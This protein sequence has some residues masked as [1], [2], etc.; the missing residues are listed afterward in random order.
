MPVTPQEKKRL[1]YERDRRNTY[2]ENDKSSRK[3]IP[4]SKRLASR[5]TRRS[6]SVAL[7]GVRGN[8]DALGIVEISDDPKVVQNGPVDRVEQRIAGRRL[9][10]F[11]KWRD[12]PLGDVVAFQLERRADTDPAGTTTADTRIKQVEHRLGHRIR[13]ADTDIAPWN[14]R[15][16]MIDG[17]IR[18]RD[19]DRLR[20]WVK[21]RLATVCRAERAGAFT[22]YDVALQDARFVAGLHRD[23]IAATVADLLPPVDTVIR[24]CLTQIPITEREIRAGRPD[25]A[26]R[27]RDALRL[28]SAIGP[29]HTYIDDP[30]LAIEVR[31]WRRLR[32][33]H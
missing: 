9:A 11:R 13:P 7:D 16:T 10:R 2:G 22:P 21:E 31:A 20:Q 19:G 33:L 15:L 3:N 5:A 1:S 18:K 25:D 28:I 32:H 29:L 6:A 30:T 17:Q 12:E 4:R 26:H 27:I 24:A 8:I 23:R 14:R